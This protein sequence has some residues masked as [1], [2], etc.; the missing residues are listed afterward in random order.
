MQKPSEDPI[1]GH[2]YVYPRADG[3]KAECGGPRHCKSCR[4]DLVLNYE[5]QAFAE[6]ALEHKYTDPT[7]TLAVL[8][9]AMQGQVLIVLVNRLG[10]QVVV[11]VDEVDGTGQ[12]MLGMDV[13][14][15][16]RTFTFK[17]EKKS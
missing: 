4:H 6:S 17:T 16:A 14:Q 10:G 7:N 1:S 3:T 15:T 11:P 13:D 9:E 5:S 2:G 12:W 8:L